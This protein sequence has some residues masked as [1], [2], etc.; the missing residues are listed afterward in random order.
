MDRGKP[1]IRPPAYLFSDDIGVEPKRRVLVMSAVV[2]AVNTPYY[3][4]SDARGRV[5][6][7]RVPA[8]R[9]T[10]HIWYE[11]TLPEALNNLTREITI[12]EDASSL[13]TMHLPATSMAQGHQNMY[14]RDYP[15]PLPDSPSYERH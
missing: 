3:G 2:V 10:L 14:G 9:Y 5:A 7:P 11:Q 6:I 4:I 15:P 8:G 12:S 1:G 13:G